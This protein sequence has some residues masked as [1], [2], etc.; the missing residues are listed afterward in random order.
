MSG[1]RV[2]LLVTGI[3]V[4]ALSTLLALL[5]WEDASKLA[6]G[7]Q[8][9]TGVAAV[10]VAVWAAWPAVMAP[11]GI[12]VSRTGKATAGPKGSANTGFSGSSGTFPD[13]LRVNRTGDAEG[14]D[15][16]TGVQSG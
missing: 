3:A 11:K 7:V 14:G 2:A 4:A 8:A 10:G 16:N 6:T 1:G 13:G 9:L 15:T 5:R 12:R